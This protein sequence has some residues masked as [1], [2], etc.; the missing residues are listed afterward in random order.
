[1]RVGA[2]LIERLLFAQVARDVAKSEEPSGRIAQGADL[3]ADR[4]SSAVPAKIETRS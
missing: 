3:G 1:M 2:A 4:E